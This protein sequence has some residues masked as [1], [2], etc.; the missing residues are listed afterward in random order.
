M[1]EL[2]ETQGQIDSLLSELSCLKQPGDVV[3]AA[4]SPPEGAVLTHTEM[5]QVGKSALLLNMLYYGTSNIS[6]LL[7]AELQQLQSQQAKVLQVTQSVRSL[8]DQPDSTVPPEEK[9][10]L[11]AALDH[12]QAQHQVTLQSCQ[13]LFLLLSTFGFY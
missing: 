10:R 4:V 5:L 13:V 9:Q 11:R 8:L 3:D 1:E 12:L 2:Q 7:Q 6:S